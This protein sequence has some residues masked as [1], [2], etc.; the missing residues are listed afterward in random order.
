MTLLS[1]SFGHHA[2]AECESIGR[3]GIERDRDAACRYREF[4]FSA[5]NCPKVNSW[6]GSS[7]LEAKPSDFSSMPFGM[8]EIQ[9]SMGRPK[10][11]NGS[12]LMPEMRRN[13]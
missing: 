10:M 1:S 11:R 6:A 13:R 5:Q 9:L 7:M 12:T 4:P 3:K 8:C 2:I